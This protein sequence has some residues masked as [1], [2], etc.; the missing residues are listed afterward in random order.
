[1]RLSLELLFVLIFSSIL[2]GFLW[3]FLFKKLAVEFFLMMIPVR[4]PYSSTETVDTLRI[5]KSVKS[6]FFLFVNFA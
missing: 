2:R 3:E 4:I 6:L 1:M 5:C